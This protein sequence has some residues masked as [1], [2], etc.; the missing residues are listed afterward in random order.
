MSNCAILN[1]SR[2]SQDDEEESEKTCE[3]CLETG[4]RRNHKSIFMK[5][6]F[7]LDVVPFLLNEPAAAQL[8]VQNNSD[9]ICDP[10]AQNLS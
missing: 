4:S 10:G 1:R 6:M 5:L 8:Q 3:L 2:D 7:A 9:L